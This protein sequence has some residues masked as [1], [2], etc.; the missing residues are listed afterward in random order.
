M[1]GDG[2]RAAVGAVAGDQLSGEGTCE[3]RWKGARGR[4]TGAGVGED[5][6]RNP[7]CPRWEAD[8]SRNAGTAV[9]WARRTRVGIVVTERGR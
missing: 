2:G 6:S 4:H 3:Q 9:G 7:K 1:L 8:R 5:A